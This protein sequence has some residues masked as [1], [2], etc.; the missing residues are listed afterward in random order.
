MAMNIYHI[1]TYHNRMCLKQFFALRWC[2]DL[3]IGQNETKIGTKRG[4][5]HKIPYYEVK[6]DFKVL[7][8]IVG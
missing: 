2:G 6:W 3:Q 4:P 8:C 1:I 7:K 5:K